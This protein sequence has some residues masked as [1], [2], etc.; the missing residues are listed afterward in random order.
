MSNGEEWRRKEGR[1]GQR[2]GMRGK[3][4]GGGGGMGFK[5]L[6][7]KEQSVR[8]T[9]KLP[10]EPTPTSFT[11]AVVLSSLQ[12][13]STSLAVSLTPSVRMCRRESVAA[14]VTA[15]LLCISLL[16]V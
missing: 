1:G 16:C 7:R 2:E 10:R 3:G 8:G 12:G 4:A 15:A 9:Q 5:G 11:N 14:S 6:Y 13:I